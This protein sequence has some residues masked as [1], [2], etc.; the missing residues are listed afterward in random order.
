[1]GRTSGPWLLPLFGIHLA[2]N[3]TREQP[4][5]WE[6]LLAAVAGKLDQEL[7]GQIDFLKANARP[8]PTP[9]T[10][11]FLT[12]IVSRSRWTSVSTR[13]LSTALT[14]TRES[15]P[16][17]SRVLEGHTGLGTSPLHVSPDRQVRLR[18]QRDE[19]DGHGFRLRHAAR[20]TEENPADLDLAGD[21]LGTSG[22]ST[23]AVVAHEKLSIERTSSLWKSDQN[24][25]LPEDCDRC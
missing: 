7:A 18:Y 9:T 3:R 10:S 1:M 14:R 8:A 21:H 2:E 12:T 15:C 11:T 19:S 22:F 13:Y 24:A 6:T 5:S 16:Q 17:R 4:M 20:S 25:A 23:A